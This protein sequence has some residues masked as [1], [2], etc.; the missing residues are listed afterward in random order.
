MRISSL[1]KLVINDAK[2]KYSKAAKKKHLDNI[3]FMRSK[4]TFVILPS[5]LK[6][7]FK[8]LGMVMV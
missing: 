1:E 4:F 3:S 5:N 2:Y 6:S 7:C 8:I